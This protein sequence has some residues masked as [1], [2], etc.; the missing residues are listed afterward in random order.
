LLFVVI[1]EYCLAIIGNA[2]LVIGIGGQGFYDV[3]AFILILQEMALTAVLP[4]GK[5]ND[6][7]RFIR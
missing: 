3:Y 6:Y 5:C 7:A 4:A 2:A 1:K